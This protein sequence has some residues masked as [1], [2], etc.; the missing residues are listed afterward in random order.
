[1]I[2]RP[3]RSTLFPYTTL[4]RS[5][6]NPFMSAGGSNTTIDDFNIN[7][8]FDRGPHGFVGG[9]KICAG[10]K[11]PLPLGYPPGPTGTPPGGK[12]CEGAPGKKCQTAIIIKTNG[13]G[14]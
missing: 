2:R 9:Y 1:M 6:F 10:F 8:D 3:P 5:H 4:F 13:R 11:T 14:I 12:A 7:W